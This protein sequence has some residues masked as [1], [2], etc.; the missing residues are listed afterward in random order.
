MLA[1]IPLSPRR[2]GREEGE[3]EPAAT[4]ERGPISTADPADREIVRLASPYSMS[5]DARLL[6]LVDAVR[7][8]VRREV[9][10]A[11]AEC[12]VWRGGSVIAMIRTLQDMGV[13]DRDIHLYDTFT[14]MTR[15]TTHDTSPV[16]RPALE[17]WE[18]SDGRP[19]AALFEPETF[20]EESVRAT[21]LSTGYPAERVHLVAG[22]VE[23]TLPARAPERLALLRLDT[24]WYE[25]TRHEL[26]HLYPHLVDSG[27]LVVD[28]YGHWEGCR[29]AVD[30]YFAEHPP[31]LLF[32]RV[33]Y[34]CRIGIK[35]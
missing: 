14:G 18:D 26:V 3:P 25:S 22:P 10:G 4:P 5:G 30:E 24:D 15:P 21:V 31:P 8:C 12:G 35:H 23:Q 27:V 28:D 19:W 17:H 32:H 20:N 29:L 1:R 34:T 11:F 6:S 13:S 2:R 9:P 33:D 7:Y 16:D